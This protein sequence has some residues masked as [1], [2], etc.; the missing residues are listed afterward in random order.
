MLELY[1]LIRVKKTHSYKDLN[2]KTIVI[3]KGAEG[4]TVDNHNDMYIVEFINR[5]DDWPFTYD[6]R[7]DEIEKVIAGK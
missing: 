4:Y 6:F 7:E 1:I 5:K 2:G 3:P